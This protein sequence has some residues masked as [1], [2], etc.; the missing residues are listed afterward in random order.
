MV[1]IFYLF[2]FL[3]GVFCASISFLL[4]FY[5]GCQL[6]KIVFVRLAFG[7]LSGLPVFLSIILS[8]LAFSY[9]GKTTEDMRTDFLLICILIQFIGFIFILY[10]RHTGF[11]LIGQK[12]EKN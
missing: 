1:S 7:I 2:A 4:I 3:I 5:I 12:N 6:P 8:S 10:L 11:S 9:Y